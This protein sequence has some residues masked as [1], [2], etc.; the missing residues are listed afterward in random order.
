M[1]IFVC[2]SQ[3]S[4]SCETFEK[5]EA[6]ST[7]DKQQNTI[8]SSNYQRDIAEYRQCSRPY[9]H[10]LA[11]FVYRALLFSCL[12][13]GVPKNCWLSSNPIS[14]WRQNYEK[15][16]IVVS[17]YR[18]FLQIFIKFTRLYHFPVYIQYGI[19]LILNNQLF[20]GLGLG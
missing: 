1:N 16:P 19:L 7:F 5:E 10:E 4:A 2:L 17:D 9:G 14:F 15:I 12:F 6:Q 8:W 18:D 13:N 11:A 20:F 3:C